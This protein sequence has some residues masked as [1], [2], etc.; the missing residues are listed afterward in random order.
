M[1]QQD[2]LQEEQQRHIS[3]LRKQAKEHERLFKEKEVANK[4]QVEQA[5]Q[6][7]QELRHI[8]EEELEGTHTL[9][10][11]Y[12]AGYGFISKPFV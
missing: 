5:V 11:T 12:V 9:G 2:Q 3:V 6:Q 4:E 1:F 7:N 8:Q 10:I